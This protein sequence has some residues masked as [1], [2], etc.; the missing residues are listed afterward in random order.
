MLNK[1]Y[2]NLLTVGPQ[3]NNTKQEIILL[4]GEIIS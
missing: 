2:K 3:L 1:T 4:R